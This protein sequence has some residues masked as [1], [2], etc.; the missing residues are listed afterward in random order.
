M[1][2]DDVNVKFYYGKRQYDSCCFMFKKKQ[3]CDKLFYKS[4]L[5]IFLKCWQPLGGGFKRK[6]SVVITD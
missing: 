4:N 3:K 5:N 6:R 1:T 2:P